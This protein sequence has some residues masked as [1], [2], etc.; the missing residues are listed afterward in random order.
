[1]KIAFLGAARTV[2]GSCFLVTTENNRFLVDCGMFQGKNKEVMLNVDPFTFEPASVDFMFLTHAHI[3]HSG[4]IPKLY[5]DGF[6][7][8]IF[9]TYATTDLCRVMLPDSGHIQEMETQ[10]INKKRAR[11]G[12]EPIDPLYTAEDAINCMELFNPVRYDEIIQVNEYIRV[13]FRDAGHMLGSAIIEIWVRE[14]DK[15][16]KAVFTG[17][18]GNM[19]T[20]ILRD[21]TLIDSADMLV[22]ESTYGDRNHLQKSGD[23]FDMFLD[24]VNETLDKGGNVVIPSFAVGRTQEIVYGINANREKYG[25][26]YDRLKD[27]P[28]YVDSPLAISATEIYRNN[29][30][31]YDEEAKEYIMHGDNP[32]DFPNLRFSRTA[33]DSKAIN[34]SNEA[35]IIISAS[36]MCEAGRIRHHLKH[37]LWRP[38]CT[39]LFVGYQAQGTLGRRL[40]NGDKQVRIFGEDITVNARIEY[41]EGFSGHADQQGLQNWFR[42]IENKPKNVFIVHGEAESQNVLAELLKDEFGVNTII[43]ER[44]DEFEISAE[45]EVAHIAQEDEER[46]YRFMC[47]EILDRM[48]VLRDEVDEMYLLIKEDLRYGMDSESFAELKKKLRGV[49]KAIITVL[50]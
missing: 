26:K 18:L 44:G 25:E 5:N 50:E 21:P 24:I 27:I 34:E 38:E 8:Q 32:V 42:S 46:R 48:D 6:K 11:A 37:H 35:S 31:C 14:G 36:G 23:R 40:I 10:W 13:R 28:V 22:M 41:I 29:V 16:T 20:P 19:N 4:R 1:M 3:D 45:S 47:L 30:D 2:T 15:E 43:P 7:G 17:D 9:T 33:E 12:K 39:I 49:E